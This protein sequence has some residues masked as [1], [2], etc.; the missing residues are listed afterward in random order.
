[1]RKTFPEATIDYVLNE[2]IA[3][4]FEHH[5]DI[6]RLITFKKEE[7]RDRSI[8]LKKVHQIM[9][10]GQYDLIVD[11]R[12]TVKTLWFSLFSLSTPYRI[13]KRKWYNLFF[14]NYPPNISKK[15][16]LPNASERFQGIEPA[17]V[18]D[19]ANDK[20]LTYAGK[21]DFITTDEVWRKLVPML[22]KYL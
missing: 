6:D 20:K 10:D 11:T 1:L 21:F 13:G 5:P 16:W 17:D 4:L 8:Y 7:M 12:A 18:S 15:K 19:K 14:H 22:D 3:P 9:R 2:E